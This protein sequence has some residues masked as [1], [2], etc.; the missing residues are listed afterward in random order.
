MA[1]GPVALLPE[2][3]LTMLQKSPPNH[4]APPDGQKRIEMLPKAS[5][6]AMEAPRRVDVHTM[7]AK[8]SSDL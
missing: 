8:T 5:T 1:G 3:R 7:K 4:D 6:I 2:G